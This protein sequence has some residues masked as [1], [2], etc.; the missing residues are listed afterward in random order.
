MQD[1]KDLLNQFLSATLKFKSIMTG[2]IKMQGDLSEIIVLSEID[3]YNLLQKKDIS[4][5][6]YVKEHIYL[7]KSAVSQVLKT[8]EGKGLVLREYDKIDRRK[9]N[10]SLTQ[11]GEQFLS[12]IKQKADIFFES[13]ILEFGAQNTQLFIEQLNNLSDAF[14]KVVAEKELNNESTNLLD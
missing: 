11:E 8:L 9:L 13:V 7:T 12:Q 2:H 5:M 14:E 6:D 1:I 4:C 10:I 3:E